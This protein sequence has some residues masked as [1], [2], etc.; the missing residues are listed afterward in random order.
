MVM[1]QP[2]VMGGEKEKNLDKMMLLRE[3]RSTTK[4]E[5]KNRESLGD[6][7]GRGSEKASLFRGR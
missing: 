4:K 1:G 5:F 6:I 3:K 7:M 2:E